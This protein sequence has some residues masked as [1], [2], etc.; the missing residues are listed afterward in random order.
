MQLLIDGWQNGFGDTCDLKTL[1]HFLLV[2]TIT[3]GSAT[4]LHNCKDMC[5]DRKED[6]LTNKNIFFKW[7]IIHI[8]IYSMYATK[9]QQILTNN[10]SFSLGH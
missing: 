10:Y 9:V 8:Y 5:Q 6:L 2:Y 7:S 3:S 4:S 1:G